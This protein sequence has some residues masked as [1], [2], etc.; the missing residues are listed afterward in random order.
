MYLIIFPLYIY[1][2]GIKSLCISF[3]FRM[4]LPKETAKIAIP[5]KLTALYGAKKCNKFAF[6]DNHLV[7]KA[8][9]HDET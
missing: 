2:N 7:L 9:D 5:L 4:I 6:C 1:V 3:G 8:Y